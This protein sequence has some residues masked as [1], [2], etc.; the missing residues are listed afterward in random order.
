MSGYIDYYQIL[1][2]HHDAEQDMIDAAYRCLSKLYHPDVNNSVTSVE[3]MKAINI[4]Y[5]VIGDACKR[6]EYN[7]IWL[8]RNNEKN[9]INLAQVVLD[10][11]FSNMVDG[12]WEKAYHKLTT[13]DKK[14]IPLKEFVEWKN[15]VS[16][17]YKLGDYKINYYCK[18]DN[19]EY[20]G[21]V[22]PEIRQFSINVRES[23]LK[24]GQTSHEQARKHTAYEQGGW[25][26]CLGYTDL[27]PSIL[28]FKHLAR[29]LPKINMDE[30]CKKAIMSIDPLTG[31]LSYRGF[32]EQAE[33][34]ML[35]SQRYGN[36]LSL[37]II[38]VKLFDDKNDAFRENQLNASISYISE[39]LSANIRK[40]DIIG[41]CD[42]SSFVIL[43]TETKLNDGKR[44]LNK[45]LKLFEYNDDLSHQVYSTCLSLKDDDIET[46]LKV[47]RNKVI[48]SGKTLGKYGLS[49]ILGFNRKWKNHF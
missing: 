21:T 16:Q 40:T 20:A 8:Q 13:V 19:C 11:Y 17:V 33:K 34:E 12:D 9:E 15:T 49:D 27:K 3:L 48:A 32:I 43:F 6:K 4:A 7:K 30:I 37:A 25:K 2:V 10:D 31:I 36:P 47:N 46:I 42:D 23:N 18:Y 44:A 45:L 35:R 38:T 24:T 39:T 1:Q 14:N 22:Y 28:K 5:S 26:V 29:T 41:R